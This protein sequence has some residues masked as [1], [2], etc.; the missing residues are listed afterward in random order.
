MTIEII[1]R[2]SG[3]GGICRSI[4]AE[5]P[6]WFGIPES[7]A[8]YADMAEAGPCWIARSGDKTL[9]LMVLTTHGAD[10]WEIH[11][12]A[13]RPE[14][15][16]GGVGRALVENAVCEAAAAGARYLTVKTQ[17]PSANYEPYACTRAFYSAMGFV[18]LEEFT[19]IWG[20]DNPCLFMVV[21]VAPKYVRQT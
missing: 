16:R 11:L 15:H 18:A 10:A 1:R 13:V 12:M 8:G 6:E 14:A 5:L 2:A 3:S 4:L 21:P 9:G 19:T 17:G 7:N 20:P